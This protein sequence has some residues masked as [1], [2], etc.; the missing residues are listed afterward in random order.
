LVKKLK[1]LLAPRFW[2]VPKKEYTWVVSPKPGPH[3]KFYCIPLQIVA[4]NI[5]KIAET[6]K[7]AMTIIRRGEIFVDG[8][9]RKDHGY[10]VGLFDTI[11][12]PKTKQYYRVV[13]ALNGLVLAEISEK[14]SKRKISKIKNKTSVRGKLQLNLSD[15]KNIFAA[16][17]KYK[18]GDSLLLELPSLKIIEHIPLAAGNIGIVSKG[19]NAGKVGKIK[20]VIPGTIKEDPK[21]LCDIDGRK[22]K[23]LKDTFFVIGKDK[24]V[25]EIG[26]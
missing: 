6:A 10:P 1:R 2:R 25:I 22:Q 13:P 17:K 14:E 16:D 21:V 3:P 5:L 12:L 24:P 15:G 18:T 19:K 26:E 23:I 11:S 9:P 7:E 20:E 4:R 8:K